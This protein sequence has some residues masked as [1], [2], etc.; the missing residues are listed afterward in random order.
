MM[1]AYM[2]LVLSGEVR[3]ISIGNK[4]SDKRMGR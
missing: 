4:R 3:D 1:S 2:E